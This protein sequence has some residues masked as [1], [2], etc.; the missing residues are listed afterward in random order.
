MLKYSPIVYKFE[1][2]AHRHRPI[3]LLND[4][5]SFL[6]EFLILKRQLDTGFFLIDFINNRNFTDQNLY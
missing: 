6:I 2:V 5:F 3:I 4:P 1:I